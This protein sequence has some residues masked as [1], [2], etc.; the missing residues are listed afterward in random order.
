[1]LQALLLFGLPTILCQVAFVRGSR[2]VPLQIVLCIA[3]FLVAASVPVEKFEFVN[4]TLR[5]WV[6]TLSIFLLLFLPRTLAGL[7]TPELGK[8]RKLRTAFVC[9]LGMLFLANLLFTKG[10]S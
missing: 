8:Q 6:V 3:G 2:L 7:L 9:V 5:V 4:H 1:M 10:G